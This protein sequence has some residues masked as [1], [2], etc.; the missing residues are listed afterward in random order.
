MSIVWTDGELAEAAALLSSERLAEFLRIAVTERDAVEIHQLCLSV[1]G[2]LTPVVGLL[3]IALRNAICRELREAFG[4]PDWLTN[5]PPPFAWKGDEIEKLKQ[6]SAHARR[7]VYTK[8]T[9]A[10]KRALDALAFPSGPPRS[11][12]H[13][14]RSKA[15]QKVIQASTGQLIAQLTLF[16]WKRLFSADYEDT[17]WKRRLRRLFP[18][19][20]LSRGIVASHLETLYQARNRV[21]HHEPILGVRLVAVLEAV[22][23]MAQEFGSK[24]PDGQTVVGKMISSYREALNVEADRVMRHVQKFALPPSD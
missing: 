10:E 20:S 15:R 3:E 22:D 12:S 18:N 4:V 5:P 1:A 8:M 6:G 7:A 19:K 24:G 11:I 9:G 14:A 16:F 2:A 13:E 21:A 23:F 17:L